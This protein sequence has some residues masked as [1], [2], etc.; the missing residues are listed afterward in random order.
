[1]DDLLQIRAPLINFHVLRE[2]DSLYLIDSGFTGG[3]KRL[4]QRLRKRG[5][6]M[7]PIQGILLTH[8]HLDH[9]FNVARIKDAT[10]CQVAASPMDARHLTGNYPYRGLARVCG[11]L[12]GLGR[13]ILGYRAFTLDRPLAEGDE[14]PIWGGLR[15]LHLPG[16]T[17][18]HIGFHC[19]ARRLVFTG[20]L[21]ASYGN[22]PHYPP[23]IFNSCPEYFAASRQKVLSLSPKGL[24][25]NHGDRA[26]PEEHWARFQRLKRTPT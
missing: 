1:M 18:G 19:P 5:W 2:G 11:L 10:D 14:L 15:V 12:E 6:D 17:A 24:I 25:P 13:S 23:A 3:W 8:G 16:H 9:T 26:S 7:L 22:C 4:Q 21:F 20:D